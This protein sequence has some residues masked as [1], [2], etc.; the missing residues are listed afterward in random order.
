MTIG[1]AGGEGTALVFGASGFIGRW[2]VRELLQRGRFVVGIVREAARAQHAFAGWDKVPELR[3]A[4]LVQPGEAHAAIASVRPTVVFNLAGYGVDRSE[5]EE[6]LAERMNHVCV[7][8]L[9]AACAPV[10]GYAG[11]RLVHVGS[12]LEYGTANGMLSEGTLPEPNTLYG[13]TKLAGTL[14]VTAAASRH[15]TH[16]VTARLFTV[17]G[18]GEHEGRLFPSL[19]QAARSGVSL[20]LSDGRQRRDFAWAG[21]V[22]ALL[23]DLS[24]A[25][26]DPGE[27][28]N[29]ASGHLHTV[30]E[31]V[32]EC[33]TQMRLT[34]QQLHFGALPTRPEEMQHAGVEVQRLE[35]LVGRAASADLAGA[36]TW[37]IREPL[38]SG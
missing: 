32:R 9:A 14:A 10:A 1:P 7:E 15:G 16:A 24:R 35:R 19:V 27:T 3:T 22:A 4:D 25:T 13:R 38:G 30:E 18:D 17:F 2:V 23:V 36:V 31:F 34:N 8:E 5:R 37:A 20:K 21:D 6:T 29:V 33:A 12:A 28:V 11:A 26:F